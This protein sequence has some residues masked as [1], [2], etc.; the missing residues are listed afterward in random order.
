MSNLR[1]CVDAR[2][3]VPETGGVYQTILGVLTGLSELAGEE[4]Y[5]ALLSPGGEQGVSSLMGGNLKPLMGRSQWNR[6]IIPLIPPG[7]RRLVHRFRQLGPP[8]IPESDGTAERSGAQLIHFTAQ[9]AFRTVLPSIY[10]PHDLQH[11]HFPGAFTANDLRWRELTYPFFCGQAK[12][13]VALTRWGKQDLV[14][15]LDLDPDKIYVIGWAPH[16]RNL[17]SLDHEG[18]R[19]I[20]RRNDLPESFALFPARAWKHKNHLGLVEALSILKRKGV[21]IDVVCTGAPYE[22]QGVIV[23]RMRSLGVADQVRFLGFLPE[24]ELASLY[25]L[26]RLLV[27]PSLFEG[28]GMPVVEAFEAGL[29][30]ACSNTSALPEVAGNCALLFNPGDPEEMSEA[31]LRL[32]RDEDLRSDLA[33]RGRSRVAGQTWERVARNYRA[34]YRFVGGSNLSDEDRRLLSESR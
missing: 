31:L 30:V 20:P 23:D 29:P 15:S 1:I 9:D 27:F 25:R 4:E 21:R 14:K 17:G 5:Y 11:L 26:A 28:F 22:F 2:A 10:N 12:G 3:A 18:F 34:L 7:A 16:V 6:R 32:W 19:E 33:R 8:R 24:Q 13:V